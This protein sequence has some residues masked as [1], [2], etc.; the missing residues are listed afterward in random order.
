MPEAPEVR[1]MVE[2]VLRPFRHSSLIDLQIVSGRYQKHG[3]PDHWS[4]F[5]KQLPLS[6]ET[7]HRRGKSVWITFENS[8]WSIYLTLG[9]TGHYVLEPSKHTHLH[10][11]T[12]RGTFYIDDVRNFGTLTIYPTKEAL[13][14]KIATLGMD[15]FDPH[16]TPTVFYQLWTNEISPQKY[17]VDALLEQYPFAGIGNY[18]RAEALYLAKIHPFETCGSLSKKQ[19][20]T[21]YRAIRRIMEEYYE[22]Q[23]KNGL[24][25][26]GF[27]VYQQKETKKGEKVERKEWKGRSLWWVPSVQKK[28]IKKI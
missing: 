26:A 14:E 10:F 8:T 1:V 23:R 9:M 20:L 16:L 12:N 2:K 17:V 18:V 28:M 6:I 27:Y 15:F 3:K 11:I 25:Y 5:I 19:I 21:L 7:F 22:E 13:D 4:T 24:L